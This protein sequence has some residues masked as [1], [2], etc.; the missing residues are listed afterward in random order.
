M[1]SHK[2]PAGLRCLL[3]ELRARLREARALIEHLE[4]LLRQREQCD[5]AIVARQQIR[6]RAI[7]VAVVSQNFGVPARLIYS[8]DRHAKIALARQVCMFIACSDL[9]L[10][11]EQTGGLFKRVPGTV[12]KAQIAVTNL[13]ETDARFA[14]ALGAVQA[15]I[16]TRLATIFPH[17]QF[18]STNPPLPEP[19]G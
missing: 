14:A 6:Q 17:A 10:F 12:I 13:A 8:R 15:E 4:G 16:K 5:L 2:R 7:I 11:R 9:K 18:E 1:D 19:A 3:R